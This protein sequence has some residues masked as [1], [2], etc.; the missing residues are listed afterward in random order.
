MARLFKGK[1]FSTA[2]FLVLA[3]RAVS[4]SISVAPPE[5][6]TAVSTPPTSRCRSTRRTSRAARTNYVLYRNLFESGGL[7]LQRVRAL[8]QLGDGIVAGIIRL[9]SCFDIGS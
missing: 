1:V 2:L 6:S 5:T 9:C 3:I 4:V 8:F 7:C